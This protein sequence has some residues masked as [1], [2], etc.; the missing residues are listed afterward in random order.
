MEPHSVPTQVGRDARPAR[1]WRDLSLRS[2]N[3]KSL[4][5]KHGRARHYFRSGFRLWGCIGIAGL[6]DQFCDQAG[7]SGLVAGAESGAVVAMEVFVELDEISPM[8]VRL[9]FRIGAA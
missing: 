7:P 9:E 6:L 8:R 4:I 2:R 5:G 1:V 3:I